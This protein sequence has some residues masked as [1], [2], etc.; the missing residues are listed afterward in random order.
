MELFVLSLTSVNLKLLTKIKS[1]NN[2][3][4]CH[5]CQSCMFWDEKS[6]VILFLL[7]LYIQLHPFKKMLTVFRIIFFIFALQQFDYDVSRFVCGH[8]CVYVHNTFLGFVSIPW[9][10]CV[11][12][13]RED[14]IDSSNQHPV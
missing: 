14:L 1:I 4:K 7:F 3:F 12:S 10:L 6:D 13:R 5:C 8:A 11:Q 2:F 9:S